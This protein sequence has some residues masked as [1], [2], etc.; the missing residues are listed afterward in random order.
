MPQARLAVE[1]KK[2]HPNWPLTVFF[3]NTTYD[4]YFE[5]AGADK[6]I[7]GD[8]SDTESV[9]S[10]SKEH[11]IVINA[12]SSFDGGLV[13]T[14]ISGMEERPA[15]SKG[16]LIHLSGTGNFIDYGTS[17]NFDPQSKTWN[18]SFGTHSLDGDI[19]DM[20]RM[21]TRMTSSLST[22]KCSTVPQTHR[23]TLDI[24]STSLITEDLAGCS[25]QANV[26]RSLPTSS[27]WP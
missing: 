19:A 17:G 16:T 3:R 21:T 15:S 12:A 14:I 10:L 22:K 9:R 6:I 8:F 25:R 2:A 11:D 18:V 24:L 4:K 26:G 27:P 23:M 20:K 5:T 1:L 13:K 7:H